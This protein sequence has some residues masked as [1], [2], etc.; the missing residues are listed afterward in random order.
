MEQPKTV[1]Q[2]TIHSIDPSHDGG[3][4]KEISY[5]G[6]VFCIE[7]KWDVPAIKLI[8]IILK[9][10]TLL[11]GYFKNSKNHYFCQLPEKLGS[12]GISIPVFSMDS[13]S[14]YTTVYPYTNYNFL[15]VEDITEYKRQRYP[16]YRYTNILSFSGLSK[17]CC[18]EQI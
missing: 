6:D 5:L 18:L 2:K 11:H 14:N 7:I 10:T 3:P 15:E 8:N 13:Y 17:V 4:Q 16:S 1:S 9:N 12:M